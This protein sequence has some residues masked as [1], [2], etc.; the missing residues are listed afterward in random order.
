MKRSSITIFILLSFLFAAYAQTNVN[1][2]NQ[3]TELQEDI[4]DYI[5]DKF[6][7]KHHISIE[8]NDKKLFDITQLIADHKYPE[9]L[10]D[11]PRA[12]QDNEKAFDWL[13]EA[14]READIAYSMAYVFG[15]KDNE[16]DAWDPFWVLL[17][18]DYQSDII[19]HI[20]YFP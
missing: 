1:D 16:A 6:N 13:E 5:I 14:N 2:E 19:G 9:V 4:E 10:K 3:L 20:R 11:E 15:L 17:L 12:I 7:C 8:F 18:L